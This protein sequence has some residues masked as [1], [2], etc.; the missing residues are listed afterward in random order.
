MLEG[1][2][3]TSNNPQKGKDLP[4]AV[5]R[6]YCS[7]SHY[8][9]EAVIRRRS[10]RGLLYRHHQLRPQQV[11]YLHG[12]PLR[13][14]LVHHVICKIEAHWGSGFQGGAAVDADCQLA[15]VAAGHDHERIG[16]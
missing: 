5:D 6:S 13:V 7:N 11:P 4:K 16:A 2:L 8:G 3:A 1:A 10:P 9:L 14:E 15:R 12:Q